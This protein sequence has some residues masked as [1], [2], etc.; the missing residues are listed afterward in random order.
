MVPWFDEACRL[1]ASHQRPSKGRVEGRR[2]RIRFA[3]AL[4]LAAEQVVITRMA[5]FDAANRAF[6][7]RLEKRPRGQSGAEVEGQWSGSKL[8]TFALFL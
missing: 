1:K 2:S 8:P 6:G 7:V 3:D 4:R 5:R